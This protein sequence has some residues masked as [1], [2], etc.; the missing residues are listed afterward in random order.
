MHLKNVVFEYAKLSS[1]HFIFLTAIIPVT[2]A[3]AM[4]QKDVFLLTILFL[5]GLTAHV[6]GFALNHYR[7]I[8]VD[9]LIYQMNKRPL[10]SGT[11]SK[12]HARLYIIIVLFLGCLLTFVFFGAFLLLIYLFGIFLASLYDFYS[13]TI[14]GMDFILAVSVTIGLVFGA[15]TVS[16]QFPPLLYILCILAFLQTLNLNLIAGGI[17]DADHDYLMKSQHLS[18]RLGVRV[19]HDVLRIP[20]SFRFIA[21][22][23]GFAYAIVV[24]TPVLLGIIVLDTVLILTLVLINIVFFIVTYKMLHL[25][26]FD[27]QEMRTYVVLQYTINWSNIPILLMSTAP[28]AG[29]MILYPV[30]GLVVSNLVL[31]RTIVRSQVM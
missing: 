28:L 9:R 2:G 24:L 6:V 14:S 13:K 25:K 18:T 29:F 20:S 22:L 23:L 4:G 11:I 12:K 16:Y 31:Y 26:R 30:I 8:E 7:D 1:A 27:R 15:A 3:I 10:I 21:Y 19:E 5:I 17:K